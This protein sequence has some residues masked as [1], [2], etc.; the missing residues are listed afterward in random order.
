MFAVYSHNDYGTRYI[1]LDG[2]DPKTW[3]GA[4]GWYYCGKTNERKK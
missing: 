1:R 3:H 4:G 2:R